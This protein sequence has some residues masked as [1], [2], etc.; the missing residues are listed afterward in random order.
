MERGS[1]DRGTGGGGAAGATRSLVALVSIFVN[2][3]MKKS[4][5]NNNSEKQ[6]QRR[7]R[8]VRTASCQ[9]QRGAACSVCD[10][11]NLP[12]SGAHLNE[13]TQ[14]MPAATPNFGPQGDCFRF[15]AMPHHTHT[16]TLTLPDWER[17]REREREVLPHQNQEMPKDS[18]APTADCAAWQLRVGVY[19]TL[20]SSLPPSS[21]C[22]PLI[23]IAAGI[24]QSCHLSNSDN[25]S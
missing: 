3:V 5:N 9:L 10:V 19:C 2:Y 7:R 11:R 24:Q 8:T 4:S 16:H 18:V 1:E 13:W 14:R 12:Q 20:F 25:C 22:L 15:M 17:E 6:K 23:S 21:A